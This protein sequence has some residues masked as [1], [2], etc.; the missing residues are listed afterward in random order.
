MAQP[1]AKTLNINVGLANAWAPDWGNGNLALSD[2]R[3]H[4][5]SYPG[6][7][8]TQLSGQAQMFGQTCAV[9]VDHTGTDWIFTI[10]PEL[11]PPIAIGEVLGHL[12][13]QFGLRYSLKLG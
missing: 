4:A 7:S 5:V 12:A 13:D 6:G 10:A 1:G 8:E 11:D 9:S 2:L 3:V